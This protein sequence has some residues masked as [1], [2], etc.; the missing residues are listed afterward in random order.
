MTPEHRHIMHQD[1]GLSLIEILVGISILAIVAFAVTLSMQPGKPPLD[2][3]AD[4]LAVALHRASA[5]AVATGYPVGLRMTQGGGGYAFA[6]HVDGSWR[7]MPDAGGPA[8]RMLPE[9]MRI[10]L[11]GDAAPQTEDRPRDGAPPVPAVWFDPAGLTE[12]FRL[13]LASSEGRVEL[14]WTTDGTV[15]RHGEGGR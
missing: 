6:R 11:E 12:P 10:D 8:G 14:A 13:R 4:R 15:E 1:A 5:E 2:E 7:A 9:G 3:E